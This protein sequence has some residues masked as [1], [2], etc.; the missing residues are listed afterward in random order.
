MSTNR[1]VTLHVVSP[2]EHGIE[3]DIKELA[4][5]LHFSTPKCR[6]KRGAPRVHKV[7]ETKYPTIVQ[8]T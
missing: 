4:A 5:G 7:S 6:S 1:R 8:R 3:H 2:C